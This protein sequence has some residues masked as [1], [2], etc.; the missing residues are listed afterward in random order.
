MRRLACWLAA[1]AF[2]AAGAVGAQTPLLGEAYFSR[3]ADGFAMQRIGAGAA[4]RAAGASDYSGVIALY[5]RY[6]EDQWAAG[7]QRLS[8]VHR[9]LVAAT[10]E[11]LI[12]EIGAATVPGHTRAVGEITYNR[13]LAEATGIELLAASDWVDSRPAIEDGLTSTFVAASAEQQFGSR[14]TAIVLGGRQWFSDGNHRD[15]LR[16]RLIFGL[17]PAHGISLQLRHRRY[18]ANDVTVPS[19]YFNPSSY[20]ETQLALS[21]RRRLATPAGGWVVAAYAGG[22]RERVERTARNPTA[23]FEL[24]AEGPVAGEIRLR[25]LAAYQRA[26]G[27]EAGPDYWLSQAGVSLIVPLR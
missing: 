2:A 18:Q 27:F 12:A 19:R 24:R 3:D 6:A 13:R 8:L 1:A 5:T 22:G 14:V 10:G 26:S 21:M 9:D 23:L 11:G 7:G 4:F 17:L 25:L 15:H 16:A 20:E